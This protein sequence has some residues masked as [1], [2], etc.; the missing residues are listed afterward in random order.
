VLLNYR[1]IK[2]SQFTVT[3]DELEEQLLSNVVNHE[4]EGLEE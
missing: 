3:L 1:S 4:K 2:A